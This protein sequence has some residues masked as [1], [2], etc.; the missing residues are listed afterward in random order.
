MQ[1]RKEIQLEYQIWLIILSPADVAVLQFNLF[2]G[3][4]GTIP[5]SFRFFFSAISVGQTKQEAQKLIP[6]QSADDMVNISGV[7]WV[8][9]WL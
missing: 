4:L 9:Q 2:K 7:K 6:S 5:S 3:V 8:V 1:D